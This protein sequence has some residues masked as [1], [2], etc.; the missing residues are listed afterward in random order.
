MDPN[1]L[2]SD[3]DPGLWPKLDP[4]PDPW[5]CHQ[6]YRIYFKNKMSLKETFS[7]LSRRIFNLYLKSYTF[8]LLFGRIF[9]GVDPDPY[10]ENGSGSTKLL[11][12]DP[13]RIRSRIHNNAFNEFHFLNAF[14]V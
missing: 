2:N 6:K 5:F 10:S 9:T 4:D 13:I 7:Q 12:S 14:T 8:C 1:T 11:I 3:P